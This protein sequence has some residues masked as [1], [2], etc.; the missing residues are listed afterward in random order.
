MI[1]TFWLPL[2]VTTVL[3]VMLYVLYGMKSMSSRNVLHSLFVA[4]LSPLL[5]PVG[6]IIDLAHD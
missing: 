2:Y 5:F 1:E 4:L 3:I 6:V